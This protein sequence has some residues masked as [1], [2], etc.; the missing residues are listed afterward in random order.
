MG[1]I[2]SMFLCLKM[3]FFIIYA[4]KLSTK[5]CN[6]LAKFCHKYV[7]YCFSVLELYL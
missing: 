5:F 6:S 3:A 4:E 7:D 2:L 1:L